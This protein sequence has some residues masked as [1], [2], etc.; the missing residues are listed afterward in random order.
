MIISKK[1]NYFYF[2]EQISIEPI[3]PTKIENIQNKNKSITVIYGKDDKYS[4]NFINQGT[5]LT[6]EAKTYSDILS[7]N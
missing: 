1:N 3:K 5:K 2:M 6:I 7:K 4:I